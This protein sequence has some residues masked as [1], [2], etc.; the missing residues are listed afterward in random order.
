VA[1]VAAALAFANFS[2]GQVQ[3]VVDD[4]Q[5]C[6]GRS[7][8]FHGFQDDLAAVVHVPPRQDKA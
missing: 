8:A 4:E 1:A 3:V 2:K 5:A 7:P 6:R